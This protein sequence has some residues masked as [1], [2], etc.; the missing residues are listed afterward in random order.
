VDFPRATISS[1]ALRNNLAVVR[2][3]AP[4]SR[5]LAAVKANAYGHG[6]VP[7]AL[8]LAG[9]DAFGLARLEEALI[10]RNAGLNHP[11]VLLE[12][13]VSAPDL[14]T[15]AAHNF[16]IVV[17]AFDQIR[18][19]EAYGGPHRF[20][21]WLKIDTGMHRVGVAPE[22]FADA[23]DRR[24][25]C[26]AVGTLRLM[27]HLAA[28]EAPDG[29]FT[30][31]QLEIF[32]AATRGLREERSIANSAGL[33]GCP[34]TRLDWVRPGLMLYGMSP[35]PQTSAA[36]LGLKPVMT[37]ATRL[38]AVRLVREGETVGYGGVWRAARDSQVGVAAIGYGDGYP[39]TMPA[40]APVLL[41][42]REAPVAG[43]VSMDMTTID[44]TELP[45]AKVGD[46]VVLFGE[47]LPA[48]R[49]ADYAST[50][51]YELVCRVTERVRREWK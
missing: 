4:T 34:Q 3:L 44:L 19:L 25:R 39:R 26:R 29:S 38:I 51:G 31:R 47:G 2:R 48:E 20:A 14:A 46:E 27:T 42:G 15:S 45:G 1:E 49:V 33:I 41:N 23:Y 13:V 16:E 24:R 43:R 18:M 6:L 9:A 40:G 32:D 10:L 37:L 35:M 17:H 7:S 22:D 12:G 36:E 30:R 8:A 11:L 5:V 28:A 21:V 50:L